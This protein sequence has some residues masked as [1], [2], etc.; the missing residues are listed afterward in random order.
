MLA[1]LAVL[2][3]ATCTCGAN[4]SDR[5]MAKSHDSRVRAAGESKLYLGNGSTIHL[6]DFVTGDTRSLS[7][8]GT[9]N[10]GLQYGLNLSEYDY[11]EFYVKFEDIAN[12]YPVDLI[13]NIEV[14]QQSD[15]SSAKIYENNVLEVQR[16]IHC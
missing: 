1:G 6:Y 5:T 2:M 3:L 8:G 7:Y 11:L 14:Q 4:V 15:G 13:L 12:K 9:R 10:D 16:F